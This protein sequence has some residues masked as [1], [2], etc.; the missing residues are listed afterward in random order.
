M[1]KEDIHMEFRDVA[2]VSLLFA[3]LER[4]F[5]HFLSRSGNEGVDSVGKMECEK[6]FN[7][8]RIFSTSFPQPRVDT[9]HQ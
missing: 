3:A 6:V 1:E 9:K 2:S 8:L 5:P 7:A 4:N